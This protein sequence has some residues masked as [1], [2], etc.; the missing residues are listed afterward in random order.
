MRPSLRL[1]D[2]QN[3]RVISGSR[4]LPPPKHTGQR[5]L[6]ALARPKDGDAGM[7]AEERPD[8]RDTMGAIDHGQ[9][10]ILEILEQV[11]I[12]KELPGRFEESPCLERL[13]AKR[14]AVNT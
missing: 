14:P 1:E 13:W 3:C 4:F 9:S 12:F 5:S 10:I 7:A 11:S 6:A 2:E 8:V